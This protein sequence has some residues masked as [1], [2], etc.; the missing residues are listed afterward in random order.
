MVPVRQIIFFKIAFL[1]GFKFLLVVGHFIGT[2]FPHLQTLHFN[3]SIK[4][5][6]QSNRVKIKGIILWN[7]I[8]ARNKMEKL[9]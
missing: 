1:L 4:G 8:N 2:A 9:N 6:V 5:V 3:I 7:H